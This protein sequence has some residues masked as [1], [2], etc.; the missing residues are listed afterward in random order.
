MEALAAG[1]SMSIALVAN[2]AVMLIAFLAMLEFINAVL[3]W[4]GRQ[5]GYYELTFQVSKYS[6]RQHYTAIM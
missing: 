5:V 2:I 1:A 6:T 3:L 4:M